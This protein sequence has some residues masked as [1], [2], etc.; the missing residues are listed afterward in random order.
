MLP[1]FATVFTLSPSVD[2]ILATHLATQSKE[3]YDS[4]RDQILYKTEEKNLTEINEVHQF[5]R[6]QRLYKPKKEDSPKHIQVWRW[7]LGIQICRWR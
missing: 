1:S 6:N 4:L 3:V 5:H 2:E 7:R